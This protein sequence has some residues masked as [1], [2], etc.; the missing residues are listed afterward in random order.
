M[1][2]RPGMDKCNMSAKKAR[3]NI[4]LIKCSSAIFSLLW[5]HYFIE[6]GWAHESLSKRYSPEEDCHR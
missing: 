4:P 2:L 3:T 6:Q 1:G 5:A